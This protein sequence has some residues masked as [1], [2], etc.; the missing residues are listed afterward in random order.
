[1]RAKV[2]LRRFNSGFTYPVWFWGKSGRGC[3]ESLNGNEKTKS[4]RLERE[5]L[6]R[7]P[8][9]LNKFLLHSRF[10][11]LPG[12]EGGV[13]RGGVENHWERAGRRGG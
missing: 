8:L 2:I 10:F 5:E 12:T 9:S 6:M 3:Q 13:G 4:S 11:S 7:G 1:M